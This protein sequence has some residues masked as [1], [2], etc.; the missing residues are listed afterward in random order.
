MEN[1][2]SA[3][4]SSPPVANP[5]QSLSR[6][7]IEQHFYDFMIATGWNELVLEEF[8]EDQYIELVEYYASTLEAKNR[9]PSGQSSR[10]PATAYR[11]VYMIVFL[12]LCFAAY[13][14]FSVY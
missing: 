6:G 14:V 2:P 10:E 12:V 3:G 4:T 9:W 7:D 8:S 11:Y 5:I 1:L 13:W